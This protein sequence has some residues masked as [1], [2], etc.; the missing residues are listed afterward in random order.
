MK[1]TTQPVKRLLIALCFCLA[2]FC[3]RAQLP[4]ILP[5]LDS[6]AET[7]VRQYAT[8]IEA[9]ALVLQEAR[10]AAWNNASAA[11]SRAEG[12]YQIAKQDSTTD[13]NT[14]AALEKAFKEAQRAQKTAEKN[15]NQA[16]KIHDSAADLLVADVATQRKNAPKI[17]AQLQK[18]TDTPATPAEPAAQD[19]PKRNKKDKP[20]T[21]EKPIAE[22]LS[23]AETPAQPGNTPP[24]PPK[25]KKGKNKPVDT[26]GAVAADSSQVKVKKLKKGK[27]PN[28]A[29]DSLPQ[30]AGEPNTVADSTQTKKPKPKKTKKPPTETGSTPDSASVAPEAAAPNRSKL[31]PGK[32]PK[33]EIEVLAD[34][35]NT[36]N[37]ASNAEK[38]SPSY[39]R[40]K[41]YTPAEDVL[42][43]PPTPPCTLSLDTRDEFSGEI[44]RETARTELFR[45]T[46]PALK[47][48][49]KGKSHVIC[50]ASIGHAGA[51]AYLY[52]TFTVN[53]PNAPR[54]LGSLPKSGLAIVKLLNGGILNLYNIRADDGV[55]G[56]D[57][58]SWVFRGQYAL[59]KAS[60]R[61]IRSEELDK[62]RLAWAN[63]Y[64][65]YEVHNVRLLMRLA[66]CL[67]E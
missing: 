60:L 53:D 58:Q 12:A 62:I 4:A 51:Q 63:G 21:P 54:T 5:P 32:R 20:E 24:E 39:T 67:W 52:L 33:P 19:K 29:Q 1:E 34:S 13:K 41:P 66:K 43:N 8:Q 37:P 55:A 44:Q 48:Y 16:R 42:L 11:R 38:R 28:V 18:N 50:E 31:K 26:S 49:I 7:E 25:G 17:W 65:D 14:L 61:S 40:Y 15:R 23:A 30:T 35:T 3:L 36:N 9:I 57:G 46:N 10:D 64:E 47:N 22:I 56:T 59:D 45:H 27:K 6:L 2:A